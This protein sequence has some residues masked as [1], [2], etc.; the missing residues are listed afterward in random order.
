MN[1]NQNPAPDQL[2]ELIRHCD[3]W[4]GNHILWVRKDG[5]VLVSLVPGDLT[6]VGFEE[7]S[8][9]LQLRFPTFQAGN[10]Y[11]G[12]DAAADDAWIA[13]VFDRLIEEWGKVKGTS[14][15]EYVDI[16]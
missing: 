12:S 16:I 7:S 13:E 15:V 8:S 9:D 3:D 10:E 5:E 14:H 6:P 2:R 4:A 11:V 1:L